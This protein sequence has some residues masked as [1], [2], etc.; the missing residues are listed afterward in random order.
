[1][2]I[3]SVVYHSGTGN[4]KAMAEAAIM[5]VESVEG[6]KANLIAIDAKDIVEGRWQAHLMFFGLSLRYL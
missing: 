3:V 2:T 1:M 6:V 5:G 4:T